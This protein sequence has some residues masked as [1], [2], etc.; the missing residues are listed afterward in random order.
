VT[1]ALAAYIDRW[2]A[3]TSLSVNR[4]IFAASLTV[5]TLTL[6]V[7]VGTAAKELVVAYQFG[8]TDT[9]DA[10]LIAFLLPSFLISV[11]A[12][13]LPSAFV[14][15][16]LEVQHRDGQEEGERLY[17]DVMGWSLVI[18]VGV[19]FIMALLA[20]VLLPLLGSGFGEQKLALTRSLYLTM[21]PIL[22][23]KGITT[24]WTTRLNAT[25]QFALPSALPI[26]TPILIVAALLY[27]AGQWG[28]YALAAGIVSGA[29]LE[30]VV[31]AWY[32]NNLRIALI[33]RW[34]GLSPAL[35]EVMKQY[36]P[37]VAGALVMSSAGLVDQSMAAML[38]S[39]SVSSLSYGNKLVSLVVGVGSFA[40]GT[41]VFPHFSRMA[42]SGN[43]DGIKHTLRTYARLSVIVTV[44]LILFLIYF[45]EPLVGLLF[46]R[47]AFNAVDMHLV[48][49][50][51]AFYLLQVPFYVLSILI[52]RVISSVK[53]NHVLLKGAFISFFLNLILNY[54]CMR[55]LGVA[56]IA[57]S[58]SIVYLVSFLFLFCCLQRIMREARRG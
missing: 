32:L 40:I 8:T 43:W 57:L 6:L 11:V 10:F 46:K 30:F 27:G 34:L 58:T 31:I 51:Q 52:V 19:S 23:L 48:G 7:H 24:I 36:V 22:M 1:Q 54:F 15:V 21:L 12:G 44:P 2:N 41:A 42:T 53:A 20:P 37:M 18:L 16:Y 33:P 56:G 13:S 45:S 35:S 55:W 28:I 39:G 26:L 17:A 50:V 14:P 25:N 3:W 9:L 49:E 4:R 38:D 47:G 29:L 5:G